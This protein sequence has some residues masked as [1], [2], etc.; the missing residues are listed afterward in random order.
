M[1]AI[2]ISEF[3]GPEVLKL[4][5]APVPEPGSK[6]ILVKIEVAGINFAD[7]YWRR[8][9]RGGEPPMGCGA[10]GAGT[11]AAVGS[12]VTGF[13]EG[14]R[15]AYW[16]PKIG[17]YAEYAL[18]PDFRLVKI[19]DDM[20]YG[21]AAAL[22]LQGL[23][24]HYLIRS[25]PEVRAGET[26]L[27]HA[28]AGGVGQIAVQIAKA[29]GAT[30]FVTVGNE[31][32]SAFAK[33]IGADEAILYDQVDFAEAARELTGG[34]GV[35][36]VYDSIGK[37]TW[38]ASL[39]ALRTRGTVVYFGLASGPIPEMDLGILARMGSLSLIRTTL[40]DFVRDK[41]EISW[42]DS[43]MFDLWQAGKLKIKIGQTYPLEEAAQAQA[44]MEARRTSGKLLLTP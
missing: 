38:E 4:I 6:E 5:D 17:A 32:K 21:T 36:V 15:V 31:E 2:Q 18:C 13:S 26:I 30:V 20:D 8:G 25:S 34:E 19:P 3:G 11:V 12:E 10:E 40:K 14:D 44:D 7:I 1:K 39:K 22:M 43:E 29:Q 42:R 24:A 35:H 28:G 33:S 41:E 23:T 16:Y 9:V 27:F 37:T